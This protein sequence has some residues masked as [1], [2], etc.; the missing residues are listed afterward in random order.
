MIKIY[1]YNDYK[2]NKR[3]QDF[4][5]IELDDNG[6]KVDKKVDKSKAKQIADKIIKDNID[7][8]WED[9]ID[10]VAKNFKVNRA[11]ARA[12]RDIYDKKTK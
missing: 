8:S 2:Y 1:E 7:V 10:Y 5:V 12:S 6:K 11:T 9:Y 4:D 3:K